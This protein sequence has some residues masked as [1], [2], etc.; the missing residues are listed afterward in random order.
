MMALRGRFV[1]GVASSPGALELVEDGLIEVDDAGVIRSFTVG[2]GVVKRMAELVAAGLQV[3]TMTGAQLCV[4]GMIDT[5][6]HAPQYMYTGTAT[7]LPLMEWLQKYTFPAERRCENTSFA[8]SVYS[9]LVSRLL[10]HGTTTAVYYGS[11]HLA[12][13]KALVDTCREQGQRALV[14]KVCMDQHGAAGY[15]ETTSDSLRDTR[16]FI[17]YCYDCQPEAGDEVSRL[18]NPVVTPRF[19]PTW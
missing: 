2:G 16:A 18:V 4:P 17:E 7:D 5:H 8:A 9:R 6:V 12:A 19:I 1:H 15:E 3:Q 10:S 14:G 13:T 11:I